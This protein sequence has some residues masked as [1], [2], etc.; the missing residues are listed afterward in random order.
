MYYI[1]S[2]VDLNYFLQG[3]YSSQLFENVGSTL[4]IFN[5]FLFAIT[6]HRC[7]LHF[8]SDAGTLELHHL[9]LRSK[10]SIA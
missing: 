1:L 4:P 2:F 5:T 6:P 8:V 10:L 9:S 3:K 7:H